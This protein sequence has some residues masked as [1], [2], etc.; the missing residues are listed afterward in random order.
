MR[1]WEEYQK[2]VDTLAEKMVKAEDEL[3]DWLGPGGVKLK[4]DEAMQ[5]YLEVTADEALRAEALAQAQ[6][7]ND[8]EPHEIPRSF[9]KSLEEMHKKFAE[10]V[11]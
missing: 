3:T 4:G 11:D 6:V 2:Q 10:K 8:M 9:L 5:R 1:F 7:D